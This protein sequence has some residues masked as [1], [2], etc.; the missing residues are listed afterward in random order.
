MR[1]GTA[2]DINTSDPQ[3]GG[4]TMRKPNEKE[5]TEYCL[6]T[7]VSLNEHRRKLSFDEVWQYEVIQECVE[8]GLVEKVEK[9]YNITEKGEAFIQE[10][11][12]KK[13]RKAVENTIPVTYKAL[14]ENTNRIENK[15]TYVHIDPVR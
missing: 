10:S 13:E 2:L 7:L 1:N 15:T 4:K 11:I 8:E 12:Q 14:N 6:G 3:F 5:L 9:I